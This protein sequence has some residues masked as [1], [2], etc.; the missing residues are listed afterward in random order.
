MNIIQVDPNFSYLCSSSLRSTG[1]TSLMY[2]ARNTRKHPEYLKQIKYI[3]DNDIQELNKQNTSGWTALMLSC[4]NTRT[5]ST[6]DTVRLLLS[7]NPDLYLTRKI[8]NKN[9]LAVALDYCNTESTE[10]TVDLLLEHDKFLVNHQMGYEKRT[11][12]HYN[13]TYTSCSG[14][15]IKKLIDLVDNNIQDIYG[16]TPLMY[17]I[18]H[19]DDQSITE[20]FLTKDDLDLDI[21]DMHDKTAYDYAL[22]HE[23]YYISELIKNYDNSTTI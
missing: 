7:Y 20:Y 15:I 11:V 6:L 21:Q 13:D 9:V 8:D 17:A 22:E 14:Y 10:Q 2:L 16:Q 5:S 1:F 19:A 3:L 4:R 18:I 23:L 12:L